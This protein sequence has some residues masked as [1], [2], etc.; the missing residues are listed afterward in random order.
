MLISIL[1]GGYTEV[2]ELLRKTPGIDVNAKRIDGLTPITIAAQVS[3]N[4]IKHI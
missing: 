3:C 1:Q 4:H 2:V